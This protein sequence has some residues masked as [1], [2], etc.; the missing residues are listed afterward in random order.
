MSRLSKGIRNT[1]YIKCNKFFRFRLLTATAERIEKIVEGYDKEIKS[2]RS[3][4]LRM[5]W[6]MR[7]GVTYEEAMNLSFNE[8]KVIGDLVKDNLETT[9]KTGLPYF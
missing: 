8:R 4:I 2:I 1:V 5:C 6:S 3:D 9:K 7:G